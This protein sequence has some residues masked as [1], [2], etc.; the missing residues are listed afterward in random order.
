M[1]PRHLRQ[2]QL[3]LLVA[4]AILLLIV[5]WSVVAIIDGV[6]HRQDATALPTPTVERTRTP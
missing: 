6:T 4:L 5:S 2:R 3:W 1:T